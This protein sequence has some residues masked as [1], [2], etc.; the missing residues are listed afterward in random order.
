MKPL[1]SLLLLLFL[2][3]NFSSNSFG[4][5]PVSIRPSIYVEKGHWRSGAIAKTSLSFSFTRSFLEEAG[6]DFRGGGNQRFRPKYCSSFLR[7]S[8]TELVETGSVAPNVQKEE[9]PQLC[10]NDFRL[11]FVGSRAFSLSLRQLGTSSLDQPPFTATLTLRP[12]ASS[13]QPLYLPFCS[14]SS[15][16]FD[17][18]SSKREDSDQS[19]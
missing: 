18:S 12:S 16:N 2:S 19:E 9:P 3:L 6:V 15:S 11:S 10:L 13:P 5:N 4:Q 8:V 14:A 7:Y 17:H 1:G